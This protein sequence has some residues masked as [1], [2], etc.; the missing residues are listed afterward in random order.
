MLV[1]LP[2]MVTEVKEEH[3][4]K[5]TVPIFVTVDGMAIDFSAEH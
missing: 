5:A 2:G 4:M 1:T 3:S